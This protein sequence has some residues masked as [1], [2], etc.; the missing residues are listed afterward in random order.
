MHYIIIKRNVVIWLCYAW[1]ILSSDSSAFWDSLMCWSYYQA[2][3]VNQYWRQKNTSKLTTNI[4]E[5]GNCNCYDSC[6]RNFFECNQVMSLWSQH[7]TRHKGKDEQS[8]STPS[9]IKEPRLLTPVI[10]AS[11]TS[12]RILSQLFS[13]RCNCKIADM[14]S[15][16]SEIFIQVL[17]AIMLLMV[18]MAST[19]PVRMKRNSNAMASTPPVKMERVLNASCVNATQIELQLS[20]D[21][22]FFKVVKFPKVSQ[23]LYSHC[24]TNTLL[25]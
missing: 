8:Q 5:V 4:G 6:W 25:V 17:L 20:L 21:A 22:L 23:P 7:S 18:S 19:V 12:Q 3:Y 24:Y 11:G 10:T 15:R 2:G 13:E 9:H 16:S 14:A 1:Y